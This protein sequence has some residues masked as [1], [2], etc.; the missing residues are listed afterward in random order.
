MAGNVL[1]GGLIG[2]GV[3]VATGAM[4]DLTPNPV[5]LVLERDDAVQP[6]VGAPTTVGTP[7]ATAPAPVQAPP[8]PTDDR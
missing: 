7:V 8:A 6:A 3:D 2:A 5:N 1:V 4:N